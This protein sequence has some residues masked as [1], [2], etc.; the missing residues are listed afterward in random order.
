MLSHW[1]DMGTDLRFLKVEVAEIP[2]LKMAGPEGSIYPFSGQKGFGR[3]S[4]WQRELLISW[5]LCSG[6]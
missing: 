1:W 2:D 4:S 3:E 5:H 6:Y